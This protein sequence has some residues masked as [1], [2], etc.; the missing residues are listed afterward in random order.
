MLSELLADHT[1]AGIST[2]EE[3][4]EAFEHCH[5]PG[6]FVKGRTRTFIASLYIFPSHAKRYPKDGRAVN[7][8]DGGICV[9]GDMI[10]A[11]NLIKIQVRDQMEKSC[12]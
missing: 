1:L 2:V 12:V 8:S 9:V 7:N 10:K 11:D 4:P 3:P 6:Y 5:H